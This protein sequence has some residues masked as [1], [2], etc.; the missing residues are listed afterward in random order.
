[1][2]D[3]SYDYENFNAGEDYDDSSS[4]SDYGNSNNDIDYEGSNNNHDDYGSSNKH[5]DYGSSN[6]HDDYGSSNEHDDY[7]SS[8]DHDDYGSSNDHQNGNQDYDN[9]GNGENNN[10]DDSEYVDPFNPPNLD[11]GNAFP[12]YNDYEQSNDYNNE[13][14]NDYNKDYSNN[15]GDYEE[16]YDAPD[17]GS[18]QQTIEAN[19][20]VGLVNQGREVEDTSNV[21][22]CPG[23]GLHEC[24]DVCPPGNLIAFKVCVNVC[25]KRCP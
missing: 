18:H 2:K 20:R 13:N 4:Y 5:D 19:S 24:I 22:Q 8:N 12:N 14:S 15:I 23:G 3:Y 11:T 1:V 16:Q 25:V 7:G 9:Y 10:A 21:S 6:K 17:Y